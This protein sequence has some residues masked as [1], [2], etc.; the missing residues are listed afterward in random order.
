LAQLAGLGLGL[1]TGRLAGCGFLRGHDALPFQVWVTFPGD[2]AR[3]THQLPRL[4][5]MIQPCSAQLPTVRPARPITTVPRPG[6]IIKPP[7]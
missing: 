1:R 3:V 2:P 4:G 6:T 7:E 5:N